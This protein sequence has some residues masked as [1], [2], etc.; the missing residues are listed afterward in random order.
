MQA[1]WLPIQIPIE[2][3]RRVESGVR[4]V[5]KGVD[6]HDALFPKSDRIGGTT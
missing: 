4:L 2:L 1:T 3:I 6:D 5:K